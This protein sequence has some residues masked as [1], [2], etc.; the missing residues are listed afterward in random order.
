VGTGKPQHREPELRA[1]RPRRSTPPIEAIA[2]LA[3]LS[4]AFGPPTAD[5]AIYYVGTGAGCTHATIEAALL[6]AAL[7][8]QTDWI[9]LTR[10]ISY[11]NVHLTLTNWNPA[12]I[13]GVNFEGGV[14]TCGG[15]LPSGRTTLTGTGSHPVLTVE[16]TAGEASSVFLAHLELDGGTRGLDVSGD[17]FVDVFNSLVIG[18]GS[19]VRVTGGARVE[20]RESARIW[21]NSGG[22]FGAGVYCSGSGS[23]VEIRGVLLDNHATSAGGGLFATDSCQVEIGDGAQILYNSAPLGGGVYLQSSASMIGG[24]GGGFGASITNNTAFDGGG[25]LYLNGPTTSGQLTNIA[26]DDN[27]AADFGAGIALVNGADLELSRD[28]DAGDCVA[29]PR[30]VSV[31]GNTLTSGT[32]GSAVHVGQL[33]TLKLGQ[34]FVESN[35]GAGEA[36][37]LFYAEGGSLIFLEG[38]RLWNNHAVSLFEAD[39]AADI[40]AAFVSAA[41][42]DYLV[43]GVPPRFD[44]RGGRAHDG[45]RIDVL[46]SILVDQ[47]P[48]ETSGGGE[49]HG[50][51]LLLDTVAGLTT[52]TGAPMVGVDPRFRDPDNGDLSLGIDS[53]AVDSCDAIAATPVYPDHDLDPRGTDLVA[54]ADLFGPYDRGADEVVPLFADGFESGNTST[55][56]ATS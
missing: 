34:A 26:I 44:S 40:Q 6:S 8:P 53:P 2:L 35:S 49:V 56:S 22:L 16:A 10:T 3:A 32:D 31:S 27:T 28:P 30:C 11:D 36:G 18:N 25:G 46:T 24:G 4:P 7:T 42:N 51:C 14:D 17:S 12:T 29:P 47:G 54:V 41:R 21:S 1:R 38:A 45:A 52:S 48:F 39:N 13:G 20:L 43:G 33:A 15:G 9:H 5:A 37:F 23:E 19:G 50:E 55:W